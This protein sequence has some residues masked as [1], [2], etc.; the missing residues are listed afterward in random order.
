MLETL[1]L[2]KVKKASQKKD[3]IESRRQMRLLMCHKATL[4]SFWPHGLQ[5]ARL[6]CPSL[7]LRVSSNSLQCSCLENPRDGGAW[8]ATVYGVARSRTRL[9]RL[10]SSSSSMSVE[11]VMPYNCLILLL[12]SH[13][14]L[15]LSQH[16]GLFQ[17]VGSLHQVAKVLE[18]QLQHQSFQWIF[19]VDFPKDS[20]AWSPCCPRYFQES[21][22]VPWFRSINSSVLSLLYGP[23]LT[24]VHGYWKNLCLCGPLLAKWCLLFNM[25][26]RFVIV[27]LPRSKYLLI[28]WL[29][30]QFCSDFGT[31]EDKICHWDYSNFCIFALQG[32]KWCLPSFSYVEAEPIFLILLF[33]SSLLFRLC[34]PLGK[35]ACLVLTVP[36]NWPFF[37]WI[38]PQLAV[39]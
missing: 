39:S 18:L 36:L 11:S 35:W 17:L 16:K 6:P 26:S 5:H 30:S 23:T 14:A 31:Q 27:L 22:P 24:S 12:S 7:S 9:K 10:S 21:S 25:L 29:Q 15:S 13:P 1:G 8:W 37:S 20:L 2:K 34:W 28:S 3:V 19:S 32:L 38:S 4:Y 33:A